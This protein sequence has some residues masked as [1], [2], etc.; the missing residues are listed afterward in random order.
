MLVSK[1]WSKQ[2]L[3]RITVLFAKRLAGKLL[4]VFLASL[5]PL[6]VHSEQ[7]PP[8]YPWHL[9]NFWWDC[10]SVKGTPFESLKYRIKI[11]GKTN[12]GDSLYIAPVGHAKIGGI[13]LYAG[14][15]TDVYG[16]RSLSDRT[17]INHGRGGI[18]SRWALPGERLSPDYLSGEKLSFFEVA[19]YE[20]HFASVRHPHSWSEGE[21]EFELAAVPKNGRSE[22][23]IEASITD[24]ATNIKTIIG[25]IN[26]SGK[27]LTFEPGFA[28]FIEVYGGDRRRLPEVTVAFKQPTLNGR[29]CGTTNVYVVVPKNDRSEGIRFVDTSVVDSWVIAKISSRKLEPYVTD[30]RL[31][32]YSNDPSK[33]SSSAF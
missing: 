24:I 28:S 19:S 2:I 17:I 33:R 26:F 8:S 3:E 20:G 15:Q 4:G 32:L 6:V 13:Q 29:S 27:N 30:F 5:V 10:V 23:W 11:S 1:G 14:I 16:W 22:S 12:A 21:Y 7:I 18:F 31:P 25:R 9:V